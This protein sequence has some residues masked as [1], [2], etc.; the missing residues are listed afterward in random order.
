MNEVN[1]FR[2]S[3]R[4]IICLVFLLADF[5]VHIH[6]FFPPFCSH[7]LHNMHFLDHIMCSRPSIC[8]LSVL[9]CII[10]F[11]GLSSR[12]VLR[13]CS[14]CF[15]TQ[16]Y[17][18]VVALMQQLLLAQNTWSTLAPSYPEYLSLRKFAGS[19]WCRVLRVIRRPEG[20]P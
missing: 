3:A 20:G 18:T 10:T 5:L 6:Q 8:N 17:I 11:L 19:N 1:L 15:D 13:P 9:R 7:M 16:L 4:P 2:L 12:L 14:L